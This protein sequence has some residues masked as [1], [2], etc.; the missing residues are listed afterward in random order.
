MAFSYNFTDDNWNS[1][2][3]YG[4][5]LATNDAVVVQARNKDAKFVLQ[6]APF[7]TSNLSSPCYVDY[8]SNT[9]FIYEIVVPKEDYYDASVIF[10][11]ENTDKSSSPYPFVGHL[12]ANS[13]C[14]ATY[15][16]QY[17][18]PYGHDEFFVV[19][20]DP[21]GNQ[22][23]GFSSQFAFSYDLQTHNVTYL[24]GW[25]IAN[26]TPHAVDISSSYLAIIAGFVPAAQNTYNAL[27]YMLQMDIS[28]LTV[29]DTW[30]YVPLNSSWQ[31]TALNRD[32][33]NF[34]RKYV[35]SVSIHH[36]TSDAI[37]GMPSYN[38][39]FWFYINAT[40]LF[41]W[42][43]RDNGY[44]RGYGQSLGWSDESGGPY[45]VVLGNAYSFP[46]QWSSSIIY[47]Y[48]PSQF[49]S[50]NPVMPMFPT[51]Q[52]PLWIDLG[53]ELITIAMAT[54][55]LVLM[56]SSGQIYVML[57]APEGAY[58]DTSLAIGSNPAFSGPI[59][60]P[61]GTYKNWVGVYICYPCSAGTMTIDDGNIECS[62]YDCDGNNSFCPLGSVTND[63]Y[64]DLLTFVSQVV[65]YPKSPDSTTFDDILMENMFTFGQSSHCLLVS[66][67]FWTLMMTTFIILILLIMGIL[68]FF[69]RHASTRVM[70]KRIF[71]QADLIKD[72]E[73][74]VGG[75][76]S[77]SLLVLLIFA[78]N[79][80]GS[81]IKQ[82]P[83]ETSSASTF[84]CD[85][86][87][88]NAKFQTNLQS[89]STPRVD[90]EQVIFDLL[91]EQQF[92]LTIDFIN[93]QQDC[94]DVQIT[95]TVHAYT[96]VITAFNCSYNRS[97][98]TLSTILDSHTISL[99]Y[100]FDSASSIGGFRVSL[101]GKQLEATNASSKSNYLV[102]ELNFIQPFFLFNGT[103]AYDPNIEFQLTRII[104]ETDPL[105]NSGTYYYTALWSPVST[106]STSDLFFTFDDYIYYGLLKT[107]FSISLSEMTYYVM[108]VQQ[109]IAKEAEVIFHDLLFTIVCFELFGLIFIT[110]KLVCLP[111]FNSMRQF[112]EKHS[113]LIHQEH[114]SNSSYQSSK[115]PEQLYD[116]PEPTDIK[117]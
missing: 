44:Q 76:A 90:D 111:L 56:D 112:V 11:G 97:I 74:W 8:V 36:N 99:Q 48:Y 88:R 37:V 25:P 69:K 110:I 62:V 53:Q 86:T 96:Q 114:P 30:P 63:T 13:S 46:Y 65:S 61:A 85:E 5:K 64:S 15:D 3:A 35:M 72:G 19:G 66:P 40:S 101:Y 51:A 92:R 24:P 98:L 58:P 4:I 109:P 75:L 38:I 33:A 17:F 100:N 54:F 26:F 91:D 87:L 79:F 7:N 29:I 21:A 113:N 6:F 95:Q 9:N 34:T 1:F 14:A 82:Y 84:A 107:S 20:V 52:C 83:I 102:R 115:G 104:N 93:T 2:D 71:R 16:I 18:V 57:Q 55:N 89:L 32:A 94:D 43:K 27:V 73:L 10:I 106:A 28:S 116:S 50:S 60:C 67:I 117:I 81:Y 41:L 68:K 49:I 70:L 80:S 108:N 39:V 78:Y 23:Y 103:L 31:A 22:A 105:D 77:L 47:W 42:A 45:P 59:L 12:Y